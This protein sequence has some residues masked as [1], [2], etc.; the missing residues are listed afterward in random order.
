MSENQTGSDGSRP[1]VLDA[2]I[3]RAVRQMVQ[4]DPPSGLRRR[5]LA[6]LTVPAAPNPA[7]LRYVAAFAT[8]GMLVLAVGLLVRDN[9]PAVSPG[10]R[11]VELREAEKQQT[12]GTKTPELS[13]QRPAVP[14]AAARA[15]RPTPPARARRAPHAEVIPMP[16][17]TNVFG[18]PANTV[19]GASVSARES[20]S[21]GAPAETVPA[22]PIE[23]ELLTI[24]PLEIEPI[25]VPEIPA[26]ERPR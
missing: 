8:L 15:P 9:A 11:P 18:P 10:V 21:L 7:R 5:V 20:S 23:I 24:A 6:R 13:Y 2:A 14:D 19:T 1:S 12:D 3:D 17:I 26:A 25:R 16:E 4:I 22:N